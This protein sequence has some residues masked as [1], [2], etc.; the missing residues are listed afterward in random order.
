MK[1]FVEGL[2]REQSTLF[3]ASLDDYVT[4]D[5]PV[6]AVE[7]F[8]EGLDLDELGLRLRRSPTCASRRRRLPRRP[9][10][11][12]DLPGGRLISI[13]LDQAGPSVQADFIPGSLL[14]SHST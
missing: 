2:D 7:V 1:R 6:R 9:D 4:E 10:A 11:L 12:I 5:N 3:P 13:T 8:V 14:H